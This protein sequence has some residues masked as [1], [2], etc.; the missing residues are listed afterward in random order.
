L[1]GR[2][3]LRGERS[4]DIALRLSALR[5][6]GRGNAPAG[7]VDEAAARQALAEA[8][9]WQRALAQTGAGDAVA[10][11]PS[12]PAAAAGRAPSPGALLAYAYPDRVGQGRGDGRFLLASGRGASLPSM[13]PLS[14]APYI[15]AAEVEDADGESRIVLAADIGEQ[16]LIAF[17]GEAITDEVSVVWDRTSQAV[18]ARRRL[19]FGALLLKEETVAKPDPE[20]IT[21]A[22]LE[23]IALE[24]TAMLPWS[25]QAAQLRDRIRVMRRFDSDLPDLSEETLIAT[26]EN[27]LGPHVSGIRSRDGLQKLSMMHVLEAML[28]WQDKQRLD[29][30][31]PTHITVPSGSRIPVDYTNPEQPVLAVR[32]Q[33]LFGLQE[34]PKIA[35]GRLP[36]TLHL[37]SPAQR[38]VQV[39]QDLASFWRGAYF[40]VKK[41]LKVRYPKHYWPEDP[42]AAV[43][44]SRV[45][46][47][48]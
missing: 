4:A 13:Q 3:P 18:R 20:R 6:L 15:A 19:M 48:P 29:E 42:F 47:R 22:L 21:A 17:H 26:L 34:T 40:E 10:A 24:G 25:R 37:L 32:L 31:M 8:R 35:K 16:E 45:R 33:E 14:L 23:G 36:L 7:G 9:Q 11:G 39:T 2:D 27:W 38:P 30:L 5:A 41:E 43:P 1:G 28:T 44:T 12:S 46:P